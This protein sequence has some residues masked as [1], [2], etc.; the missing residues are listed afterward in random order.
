MTIDL[1][2][3]GAKVDWPLAYAN[4][5]GR[6]IA[7]SDALTA[8]RERVKVLTDLLRDAR[9]YLSP[10]LNIYDDIDDVIGDTDDGG[11]A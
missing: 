6:Y 3:E 9:V 8:E 10:G 2:A 5:W 1:E 4:L 7:I 11:G